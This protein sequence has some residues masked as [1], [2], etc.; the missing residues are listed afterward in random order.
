MNKEIAKKRMM[1]VLRPDVMHNSQADFLA[2]H[3]PMK[4]LFITDQLTV[5]AEVPEQDKKSP[6]SEEEVYDRFM[7]EKDVDQFVLVVGDSGA[8]KSH[9]I[10]WLYTMHELRKTENEVI[11]PIR[12][13][14]NTLKGTIRQLIELPEVKNLPNRELYKKLASA[15]ITVPEIELKDTLYHSFIIQIENDDGRAG[16]ED[17]ERYISNVNRNRLVAL[18]SNSLF[19]GR[20]LE[21]GGPIDRIYSKFAENKTN[22]INDSVA[23]FRPEDFEFDSTFRNKLTTA[24][25]KA[26]GMADTILRDETYASKLCTYVNRFV[27]TVIQ[28]CSGLEPGDLKDVITEIRQELKKQEKTLT[29]MI[30]D[31]TATSGVDNSLLD[32][33]LMTR[34]EYPDKNMCR[35][36]AIVGTTDAYYRDKFRGNTKGRIGNYVYVPDDLFSGNEGGL[37]EFFAK[38]LNAISLEEE[39]LNKWIIDDRADLD[40]LPIHISKEGEGWGEYKYGEK[41]INLFPF[42]KNAITIL[43]KKQDKNKRNPRMLM[44]EILE[45]YLKDALEHFDEFPVRRPV[46]EVKDIALQN[47]INNSPNIDDAT[48]IRL[49]HFMYVWG[50]GKLESYKKKG[51][52]YVS[53]IPTFVYEQLG[54]PLIDGVEVAPPSDVELIGEENHIIEEEFNNS[55]DANKEITENEQVL[56]ALAEV[57]RWIEQKEYKLNI[58]ASTKSVRALNEARKN[59]NDYLYST[60][61]WISEGVSPH[62]V[63]RIK[64]TSNKF[65]VAFDRQTKVSDAV[66]TLP[67][68]IESRRI[69]EAFVRWSEVGGKSWNFPNSTD[70]LYRI[71]CWSERIKPKLIE[72]IT[73]YDGNTIDYF[74]FAVAAE[75]YRIILNGYCK[76]YQ[77]VKNISPDKLLEKNL[78]VTSPNGHSK[79]WNDL[80]RIVNGS[81]G[82]E[83]VRECV[84][85]YYNL[86]QGNVSSSKNYEFD[87]VRFYKAVKKVLNSG[88]HYSEESLQLDDPVKKRKLYSEH[89]KKIQDKIEVVISDEIEAINNKMLLISQLVD[90]DEIDQAEEIED[91]VKDIDKFY[92]QASDSH[93]SISSHYNSTKI[94]NCKNNST[95]ILKALNDAKQLKDLQDSVDLLLKLSNDPMQWLSLFCDLLT[96]CNQDVIKAKNETQIRMNS[97]NNGYSIE[98]MYSVEKKRILDCKELMEEVKRK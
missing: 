63:A 88:L 18:M 28:R 44:R 78:P 71:Q 20:L 42:T 70:Y 91:I 97:V 75:Y 77:S 50:N 58:G 39:T 62:A 26:Q 94:K 38:Y 89:L 68:T 8:G 37:V 57:D 4:K 52:K 51:V 96:E 53:G 7:P 90:I 59:M 56:I 12:R 80:L 85:Q 46:L 36:N 6:K 9:L 10:R 23:E 41:V 49:R 34:E 93:I 81:D 13:A 31:I 54:L 76:K 86:P 66:V 19:K 29:V 79:S 1:N 61:D 73:N 43:Y 24:D 30:E 40:L 74:S 60:I 83:V 92:Q 25:A 95:N 48:K 87:Y 47:A 33:L 55:E 72:S 32:A 98:N 45:P 15:S 5:H 69:I 82:I 64:D 11:L 22:D 67:A 27:E 14:D 65:L 2:T 3:V 17:G 84:L 21:D 16:E 35:I